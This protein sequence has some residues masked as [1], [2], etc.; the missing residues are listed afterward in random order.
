MHV[1]PMTVWNWDDSPSGAVSP[2]CAY[3]MRADSG[4]TWV[5]STGSQSSAPCRSSSLS[6]TP[7]SSSRLEYSSPRSPRFCLDV[8]GD[9]VEALLEDWPIDFV[10]PPPPSRL[11]RRDP[12]PCHSPKQT[13][14]PTDLS[15]GEFD[16]QGI[17]WSRFSISR[18]EYRTKRVREYTNYNNVNW[19]A[20]LE[21]R[22][23]NELDR[24]RNVSYTHFRFGQTYKGINPTID[25]FQLRHLL[26]ADSIRNNMIYYVSNSTM[27]QF[28]KRTRTSRKIHSSNQPQQL[29]SCHADHGLA[30]TGSFDSEV[31]V[32]RLGV[33][34]FCAKISGIENSITNH[35][36]VLNQTHVLCGNND[37]YLSEIDLA[38]GRICSRKKL[39]FAVNHVAVRDENIFSIS[40]DTCD[41]VL[42]DRRVPDPTTT[43][44][45]G[46]LDFSF[47]SAWLPNSEYILATGAQD[48]TCRVWD[49]RRPGRALKCVGSL[50]GAVRSVKFSP[51]GHW[52]GFS[53]PADFVHV[54]DVHSN[55]SSCQAIDFF[56][57]IGGITFSADSSTLSVAV[58]DT[59]FGCVLDF[60]VGSIPVNSK[61]SYL[62]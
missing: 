10:Q 49:V 41:V 21:L 45:T 48:G 11:V 38:G 16:Y 19:T 56:G 62:N 7:G 50:L 36:S 24:L 26:C 35:V 1:E 33:V 12:P 37:S 9:E 8:T 59:M 32:S 51:D 17:P 28:D 52:L 25:H 40:G 43:H 6:L 39:P 44:L 53:E 18:S 23:R 54:Y 61:F 14:S 4:S 31:V 60:Q 29:A 55:F 47:S 2:S 5:S 13:I 57:N 46:H 22:R 42:T 34:I 20:Q 3:R 30:V 27:Y 15:S 58:A